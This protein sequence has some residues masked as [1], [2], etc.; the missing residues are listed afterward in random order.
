MS[1][2]S[3][4]LITVGLGL[5][6]GLIGVGCSTNKTALTGGTQPS[7]VPTTTAALAAATTLPPST[8]TG[9]A[10]TTPTPTTVAIT[11]TT[12]VTTTTVRTTPTL[13]TVPATSAPPPASTVPAATTVPLPPATDAPATTA[14]SAGCNACAP[15]YAFPWPYFAVPQLGSEPV[16]GTGCG[17]KGQIGEVIPDGVWDGHI[18]ISG[19]TLKIDL[20]CVYYGASAQ[21]FIDQC[22]A[23]SGGECFDADPA[24]FIINNNTRLRTVPLSSSFRR[25]YATTSCTDPGPGSHQSPGVGQADFDSWIVIEG[26]QATFALTSCVYG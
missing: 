18:S 6:L 19:A 12:V 5:S 26:G 25:R 15:N 1:S 13:L 16:R 9:I 7:S 17:S 24:F 21:P 20:Q 3:K 14:A 11:S 8:T 10:T 23:E 22:A 4:L 2:S